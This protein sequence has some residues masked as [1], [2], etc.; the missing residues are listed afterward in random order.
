MAKQKSPEWRAGWLARERQAWHEKL[1]EAVT[2]KRTLAAQMKQL[3]QTCTK[4][5]D[6]L[7]YLETELEKLK[8]KEAEDG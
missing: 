3:E 4:A 1:D 6:N 5:R 2:A 7:K 8:L